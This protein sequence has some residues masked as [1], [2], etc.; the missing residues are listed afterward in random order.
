MIFRYA[1]SSFGRK[2]R[3]TFFASGRFIL[4]MTRSPTLTWSQPKYVDS[5]VNVVFFQ[6]TIGAFL[7]K[8]AFFSGSCCCACLRLRISRS[9]LLIEQAELVIIRMK[10]IKFFFPSIS[11]GLTLQIGI[12][13]HERSGMSRLRL[14]VHGTLSS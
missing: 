1:V 9:L 12:F 14:R 4:F 6:C 2:K 5:S 11:V 8:V 13:T 7:E 10:S 3:T